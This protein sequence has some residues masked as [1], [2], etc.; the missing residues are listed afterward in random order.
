VKIVDAFSGR[1]VGVGDWLTTPQGP[2]VQ[3]AAVVD[4][5]FYDVEVLL[6][7]MGE[8]RHVRVPCV[9]RLFHHKYLLQRVAFI[10]S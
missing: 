4:R 7:P 6:V 9:V 5:T 1:V 8:K 10:P 2:R 3:L